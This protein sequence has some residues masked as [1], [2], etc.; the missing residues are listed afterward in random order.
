MY[1]SNWKCVALTCSK[2]G[3]WLCAFYSSVG[4]YRHRW[5]RQCVVT[6]C[7]LLCCL[8]FIVYMKLDSSKLNS[9]RRR[10]F[11]ARHCPW[12]TNNVSK[13]EA[14]QQSTRTLTTAEQWGGRHARTG[15]EFVRSL[16]IIWIDVTL[17]VSFVTTS[18]VRRVNDQNTAQFL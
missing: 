3:P 18:R 4:H 5:L 17:P 16:C 8:A 6:I 15:R 11:L 9:H 12:L 2:D 14:A 7:D 10:I 13:G 1:A